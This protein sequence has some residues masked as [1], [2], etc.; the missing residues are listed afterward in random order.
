[1][2]I[3]CVCVCVCVFS[4]LGVMFRRGAAPP[5]PIV[6]HH[7]VLRPPAPPRSNTPSPPT[8]SFAIKSP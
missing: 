5:G 7:G 6:G 8:K 4:C 3:V 2:Y 1:M